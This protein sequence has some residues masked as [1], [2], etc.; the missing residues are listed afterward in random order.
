METESESLKMVEWF[1]S[2]P[3]TER[4]EKIKSLKEFFDRNTGKLIRT[5]KD[6]ET[7]Q[8]CPTELLNTTKEMISNNMRI[9]NTLE[10]IEK[11]VD[12]AEKE[13]NGQTA[14]SG[15]TTSGE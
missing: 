14:E 5:L 7:L 1:N 15:S 3:Y 6:L 9:M 4:R 13:S 11:G 12:D 8:E 10:T 2:L